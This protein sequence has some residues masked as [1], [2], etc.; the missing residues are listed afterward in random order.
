M[1]IVKLIVGGILPYVALVVFAAGRYGAHMPEMAQ[2]TDDALREGRLASATLMYTVQARCLAALG[3]FDASQS[4]QAKAAQ[5]SE[6]FR[7]VPFL[8]LQMG[9]YPLEYAVARGEGLE[10]L[11]ESVAGLLVTTEAPENY[12]VRAVAKAMI[13]GLGALAGRSQ[14]S[15]TLLEETLPA[16][17]AGGGGSVN[18]PLLVG[19]L[20]SA[21]WNLERTDHI[22]VLERNLLTKIIEPDFRYIHQDGRLAMAWLSALQGRHDE[23]VDWFAKARLVLDEEGARPLRARTDFEEARMV[24]RRDALGDRDRAL[25]LIDVAVDQFR[26]L[27][28]TGWIARAEALGGTLR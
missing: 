5:L 17:E 8:V 3:E 10:E 11:A 27:G 6:R 7:P 15:M 12:W 18:Y 2:A 20:C 25:R 22:E 19:M 23:A 9:A 13:A 28:M 14:P 21:L 24:A 1:E 26:A 4:A 16:V